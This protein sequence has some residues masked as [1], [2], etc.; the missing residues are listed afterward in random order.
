MLYKTSRE[1]YEKLKRTFIRLMTSFNRDDFDEYVQTANSLREWIERDSTLLP[2]QKEHMHGFTHSQS[3]DWQICNQLANYGKHAKANPRGKKQPAAT[4]PPVPRVTAVKI[5]P[6]GKG[7]PIQMK[8]GVTVQILSE[9]NAIVVPNVRILGRGEE[10]AIE[11]AGNTEAALAV[12]YRSFQHFHY[13]FEIAPIP[14]F[15]RD[16][17]KMNVICCLEQGPEK[18]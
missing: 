7:W 15:E 11:I 12:V 9:G 4:D 1:R 17:T 6:D 8:P 13:I 10:I 2:C 18:P 16:L 3:L 14:T 5:L